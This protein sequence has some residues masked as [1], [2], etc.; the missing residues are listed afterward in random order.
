MTWEELVK[1]ND[2]TN[3]GQPYT[4]QAQLRSKRLPFILAD[5]D[6]LIITKWDF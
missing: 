1:L 4:T 2:V 5:K 6:I 3:R